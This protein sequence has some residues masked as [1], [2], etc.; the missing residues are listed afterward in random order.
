MVRA[1]LGGDADPSGGAAVVVTRTLVDTDR[2]G[3]AALGGLVGALVVRDSGGHR[4]RV[5]GVTDV[6]LNQNS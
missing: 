6:S 1:C 4:H 5:T 3:G 2:G